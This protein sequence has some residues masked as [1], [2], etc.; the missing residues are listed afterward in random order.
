MLFR[1]NVVAIIQAR[2]ASERLPGKVLLPMVGKPA[3][4]WCVD[5]VRKSKS[6]NKIVVA[7]TT[8]P[9]D[10]QIVNYCRDEIGCLSYRGSEDDVLGRVLK[11]AELSNADYIVDITADCP[12]VDPEQ[13]DTI[14]KNT[15]KKKCIY[16]SNIFPRVWPDGFDI[17]VYPIRALRALDFIITDAVKR[18]HVGWNIQDRLQ[19]VIDYLG[20]DAKIF[21]LGSTKDYTHLEYQFYKI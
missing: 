7:T 18:H 10:I 15:I 4:H 12:F 16:G 3:L 9:K 2:M 17:Q 8:N 1:K 14:V 19:S 20:G 6:V 21:Y 11:A 13:I 5:R